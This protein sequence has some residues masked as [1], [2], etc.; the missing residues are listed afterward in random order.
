MI[1]SDIL[2]KVSLEGLVYSSKEE[3]FF[4]KQSTGILLEPR[5]L[6]IWSFHCALS[7]V[8]AGTIE[9]YKLLKFPLLE[10]ADLV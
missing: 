2:L 1:V 8:R 7:V 3:L 5:S 4:L 10:R 6:L 9:C